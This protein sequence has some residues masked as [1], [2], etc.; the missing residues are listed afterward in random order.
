MLGDYSLALEEARREF[1]SVNAAVENIRGRS[2]SLL[3]IGGLAASVIGGLAVRGDD[4]ISPT[5]KVGAVLF[6]LTA[7]CCLAVLL[8]RAQWVG[9]DP[10]ILIDWV[11]IHGASKEQM[12]RELARVMGE[13]ISANEQSLRWFHDVF[14]AGTLF[15]VL[16]I[17]CLLVSLGGR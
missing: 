17:A 7:V 9:Q 12:D 16:E 5:M 4:P 13:Q 11:D 8:P 6:G 1:D 2:M 10:R 14:R 3:T 15:L